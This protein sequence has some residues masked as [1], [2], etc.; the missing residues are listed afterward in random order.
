VGLRF[1]GVLTR[2]LFSGAQASWFLLSLDDELKLPTVVNSHEH[3]GTRE[4][5][6]AIG[7]GYALR[8]RIIFTLDLAGG[9]SNVTTART[10]DATGNI[11][12]RERK[13]SPFLSAHEAIQADVWRHM[14]VS[15]SLLTVRQTLSADLALYPDRLGRL[16]TSGG[17]F[18]PNGVTRDHLTT[19]YSE[20]GSGWRFTKTVLAEY[21]FSTDYGVSEP[22]HV[23]LLR[24]DFRLGEH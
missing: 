10:E 12:Q 24:Y 17:T 8:P 14:F 18:A 9:F 16:L 1:R 15:G 4:S 21:V 3:H 6:F 13:S 22:S 5:S 11:L 23:F 20:F 19:Y 7:F 2:K